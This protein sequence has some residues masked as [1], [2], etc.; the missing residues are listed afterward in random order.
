M[1]REWLEPWE[2]ISDDQAMFFKGQLVKEITSTH[3]LFG[4][5]LMPIGRSEANDD[6]LVS[7]STG[8]LAVVHLTWGNSGDHLWP[9]TELYDSWEEFVDKKML[10]DNFGY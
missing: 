2:K 8:K 7:L 6:I 10:E 3:P 9:S 5:Q 1:D 4:L